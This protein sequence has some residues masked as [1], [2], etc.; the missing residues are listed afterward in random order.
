MRR[1]LWLLGISAAI[2]GCTSRGR[3]RADAQAAFAAGQQQG[4][5]Q[6]QQ[7]QQPGTNVTVVGPVKYTL[8]PWTEEMT[9]ARAIIAAQYLAT[10]DPRQIVIL[11]SGQQIPVDPK[12]LLAGEDQ[13]LL[14]GDVLQLKP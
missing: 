5:A 3:A 11:R 13:P 8:V 4:L 7:L 10:G 9:V 2:A 1:V 14:A 6:A 12:A